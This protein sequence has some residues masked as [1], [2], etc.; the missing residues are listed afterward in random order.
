MPPKRGTPGRSL[1]VLLSATDDSRGRAG[2]WTD[3]AS[4]EH[5]DLLDIIAASCGHVA[6]R[7]TLAEARR[8]LSLP[9]VEP[10]A[11]PGPRRTSTPTGTPAAA[12][13][14]WA[15]SKPIAGTPVT[16]YLASRGIEASQALAPLHYHPHCYYRASSDD[17]CDVRAAWPAMIAAVTDGA[18]DIVG[19]HRT[20][21]DPSGG[22]AAV[23]CPRRAMGHLLG[24]GVRF[25]AAGP[26]MIA[27]EG[28]E[29]LLSLR[30]ILPGLPMIACLSA[31]HLAGLALPAVLRRLYVACDNDPAGAGAFSALAARAGPMA[32]HIVPLRPVLGDFNDDLLAFGRAGLAGSVAAQLVGGDARAIART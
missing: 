22:K 13:R 16:S 24:H 2:K 15:A 1:Y 10:S 30:E 7:E 20:C 5:G 29:T 25:G 6:M 28:I 12:G 11:P 9:Q 3:A 27:G 19:V 18:G 14:L 17:P 23:A 8:F 4:G 32:I 31:A 21:L 26:V